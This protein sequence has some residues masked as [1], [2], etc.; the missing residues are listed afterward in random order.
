MFF[1]QTKH[2]FIMEKKQEYWITEKLKEIPFLARMKFKKATE[3]KGS[4]IK[5]LGKEEELICFI[6]YKK[7][8]N[9]CDIRYI[10]QNNRASVKFKQ[11]KGNYPLR[12]FFDQL[13]SQGI[14]F[15]TTK[16]L[17]KN[18][19]AMIN[20]LIKKKLI[21]DIGW[22]K[23]KKFRTKL[24]RTTNLIHLLTPTKYKFKVKPKKA[25][26]KKPVK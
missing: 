7:K 15:F 17:T 6:A 23:T 12:I 19:R 1:K 24:R 8:G 14:K 3:L 25:R 21:E 18:S 11:K 22:K 20:S 16:Q 13:I 10:W 2:D 4:K 26:Q 5:A 9:V